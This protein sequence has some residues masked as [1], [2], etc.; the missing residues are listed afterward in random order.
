MMNFLN[1]SSGINY[2]Y[3][4]MTII[5]IFFMYALYDRL[6]YI[7]VYY[8]MLFIYDEPWCYSNMGYTYIK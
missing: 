2:I 6:R 7:L 4:P 1:P 5:M 8:F 3:I